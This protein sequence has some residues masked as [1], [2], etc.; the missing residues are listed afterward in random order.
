MDKMGNGG[1]TPLDYR[2]GDHVKRVH[3]F[4]TDLVGVVTH[5]LP[6]ANKVGVQW[7]HGNDIHNP[8]EIYIVSKSQY[9]STV[10][11]DTSYG[12]WENG[13]SEKT[14]GQGLP[15]RSKAHEEVARKV[16]SKY[17][18]TMSRLSDEV[19]VCKQASMNEIQAFF[20]LSSKHK[21][22]VGDELLK[23]AIHLVY[24]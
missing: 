23:C 20:K 9:P 10:N 13:Q 22:D 4:L 24:G 2:P 3:Q 14:Y 19:L 12:S 1:I 7:A 18:D 17:S 5:I 8:E 11:M 16:A 6:K 21:G 15:K